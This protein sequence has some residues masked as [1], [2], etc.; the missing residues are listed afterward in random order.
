MFFFFSSSLLFCYFCSFPK[1]RSR[2]RTKKKLGS[3]ALSCALNYFATIWKLL[4]DES[5][6]GK[7]NTTKTEN[8]R[9]PVVAAIGLLSHLTNEAMLLAVGWLKRALPDVMNRFH[10]LRRTVARQSDF[11]RGRSTR[12]CERC[13]MRDASVRGECV[14]EWWK[15]IHFVTGDWDH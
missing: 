3:T 14:V 9:A 1:R 4:V 15:F 11:N 2:R 13:A 7:I 5:D 12:F 8:G 10:V 6:N